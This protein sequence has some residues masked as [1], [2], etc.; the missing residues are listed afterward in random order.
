MPEIARA[1]AAR[2]RT[3]QTDTMGRESNCFDRTERLSCF[4]HDPL[5]KLPHPGDVENTNGQESAKLPNT[6]KHS[7]V[8]SRS[9]LSRKNIA[10]AKAKG[11][12]CAQDARNHTCSRCTEGIC[13]LERQLANKVGN[14]GP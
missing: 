6:P 5:A 7:Q 13:M 8:T 11:Q 1:G 3:T 12:V 9:P 10:A 2:T 14:C 4:L